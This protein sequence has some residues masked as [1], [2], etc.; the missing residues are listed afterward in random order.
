MVFFSACH[1]S[2][3]NTNLVS[4][5]CQ[6]GLY[7]IPTWSKH[8]TDLVCTQYRPGLYPIPISIQNTNLVFTQYQISLHT[9]SQ[10]NLDT[11]PKVVRRSQPKNVRREEGR[12]DNFSIILTILISMYFFGN[13]TVNIPLL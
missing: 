13:A 8:N 10:P 9:Q 6:P 2:P 7:R 4:S 5:Q 11:I 1:H 12:C 3:C